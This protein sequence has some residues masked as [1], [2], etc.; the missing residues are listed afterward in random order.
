M[1]GL[2]S[3]IRQQIRLLRLIY[4]HPRT[5]RYV[6]WLT[7]GTVLYAV[8]PIDLIPDFI[9]ILGHVDDAI[10]L[11]LALWLTFKLIPHTVLSECRT[12][13][14]LER[15]QNHGTDELRQTKEI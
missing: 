13:L 6:R 5:P 10:V 8:S 1:P 3:N 11:P 14:A 9:P 15:N 7:S 12:Q 4:K 2:I